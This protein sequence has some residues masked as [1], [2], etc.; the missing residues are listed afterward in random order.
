MRVSKLI[1][2]LKISF[3]TLKSYEPYLEGLKIV[4]D[5]QNLSDEDIFKIVQFHNNSTDKRDLLINN[6]YNNN[7]Q[8]KF[9]AKV[10]WYYNKKNKGEYGFLKCPHLPDLYFKGSAVEY[11]DPHNL[12][13]D[14]DVVVSVNK[15]D[16]DVSGDINVINVRRLIDE[17]EL[18]FLLYEELILELNIVYDFVRNILKNEKWNLKYSEI[19]K[20]ED[21]LILY[22]KSKTLTVS[23]VVLIYQICERFELQLKN[24][25]EKIIENNFAEEETKY[26]VWKKTNL[27]LPFDSIKSEIINKLPECKSYDY[28]T[29]LSKEEIEY[30]II[31]GFDTFLNKGD[32]DLS[33][34]VNLIR[35]H[36]QYNIKLNY[37]KLSN[38][39]LFALWNDNE[40]DFFPVD[41]VYEYLN[42]LK[43]RESNSEIIQSIF[44]KTSDDD[45]KNLFSKTHF[46]IDEIK[47]KEEIDLILFYLENSRNKL[48]KGFFNSVYKK[49]SDFI[50]VSWFILDYTD[51]LDYNNAI[52]YT[53]LLSFEDQKLFFKKLLMLIATG[54]S[55]LSIADLSKITTID[56]KTNQLA[57]D[58]DGVGLDY[59]LSVIIKVINDLKANIITTKNVI[60]DIIADQIKKPDEFLE[61]TGFFDKCSGRTV[62]S[63]IMVIGDDVEESYAKLHTNTFPRFATFCDGRKVINQQTNKPSLCRKSGFEFWWCENSPCYEISR[64]DHTPKNWRDYTLQDALR[65]LKIDY[66]ENDYKK[67]LSVIN[68]VNK[69]LS[70]LTCRKCNSI[71]RPVNQANY[72]FYGVAHF[73]CYNENCEEQNKEIY[74]SHCLN[75]HCEN[76]IDS[77]DTVKCKNDGY[78]D[79]CGWYICD[80]CYACCSTEKINGRM[81]ILQ[82]TGQEYHCHERG[83]LDKGIIC[84]PKC[85]HET[86]EIRINN[87]NYTTK[88][89]WFIE[90]RNINSNIIGHGVRNDG[91]YWFIW[92]KG[93]YTHEEYR[94]QLSNILRSGFNIPNFNELYNYSQLV[95][96][97]YEPLDEIN[98]FECPNCE[99]IIDLKDS[100]MHNYD[101]IKAVKSFHNMLY[102][103]FNNR[104]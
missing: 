40:I 34:L 76:I 15:R 87:N 59:S 11:I 16:Y 103:Y 4:A 100:D 5:S 13:K 25:I 50:K 97:P 1:G 86:N 78:P 71:L 14:T 52:I 64:R 46:S 36:H 32:Q 88:L 61:I 83:H 67:L 99:H 91:R 82:I 85:G 21:V 68:R 75:S 20:I 63:K 8:Y 56:Y 51:E 60:F 2:Q 33:K 54:R 84:C 17:T 49:S 9:I 65:I 42:E 28:L 48:K 7:Y 70:H 89:N 104:Q 41:A 31:E 24:K 96:E 3:K 35:L 57:K 102:P 94:N 37:D 26:L 22:F 47:L 66:Q 39:Q 62:I 95:A 27:V 38:K 77:R 23:N 58:I 69:F 79:H 18:A 98:K 74:L 72:A 53:G 19:T 10:D 73:F 93:N 44:N 43:L 45:Q 29:K 80:Y 90:H 12:T 81:N 92:S 6:Y 55:N 30:V 101:R